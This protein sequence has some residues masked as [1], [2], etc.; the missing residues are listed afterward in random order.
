MDSLRKQMNAKLATNQA[1]YKR[2]FDRTVLQATKI[3]SEQQMLIDRLLAQ[4]TEY[5]RLA[6][7]P[8]A[9]LM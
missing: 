3:S 6:N 7:A 9:K 5:V 8:L 1:H 2:H 4:M